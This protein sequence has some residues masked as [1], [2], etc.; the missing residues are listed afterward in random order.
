[1]NYALF[2]IFTV[3]AV[4]YAFTVVP[5][6]SLPGGELWSPVALVV[7]CTFVVRD[8]AQRAIGHWVV[9][10]MLVG[11]IISWFMASPEV[12]AASMCAFL[13]GE[14]LDWLVFTF[15]KK[16]FSQRILLSSAVGTPID[17]L[18]FLSMVGIASLPGIAM[19]TM[20]KM[21]GAIIVFFL[22]RKNETNKI[23]NLEAS[24]R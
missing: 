17:S 20:S 8:F 6:L 24:A 12:A 9:P 19:M 3:I 1:M 14:F 13:V 7:G 16:P 22:V 5:L 11:G 4:N 10:A 18:V 23:Q 15:T 21:V 2:Y